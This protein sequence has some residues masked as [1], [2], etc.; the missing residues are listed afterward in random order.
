MTD[1]GIVRKQQFI[2]SDVISKLLGLFLM[3]TS[4]TGYPRVKVALNGTRGSIWFLTTP[5]LAFIYMLLLATA[6]Q[7]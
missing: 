2:F 6:F 4:I 1:N 7:P 3:E 5:S